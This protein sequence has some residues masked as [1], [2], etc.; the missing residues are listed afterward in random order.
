MRHPTPQATPVAQP[1]RLAGLQV[2]PSEAPELRGSIVVLTPEGDVE[3]HQGIAVLGRD[4]DCLVPIRDDLAS[5]QHAC[6]RLAGDAVTI[7]D[8]GSTNGVWVNG[9]RL[10]VRPR[11][12]RDGD[13]LLIGTTEIS[14]F[15]LHARPNRSG[16]VPV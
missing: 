6:I 10:G 7:Q 3:L 15:A 12:L 11:T 8:L 13:R 1:P 5:R 9:E 2:A 16:S 4:A 14:V